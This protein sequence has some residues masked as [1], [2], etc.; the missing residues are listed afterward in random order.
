GLAGKVTTIGDEIK[1]LQY[2]TSFNIRIA[3]QM[4]GLATTVI[5]LLH[6]NNN[7]LHTLI[8]GAPQSGK[9]T[10][11]RDMARIISNGFQQIAPKKVAII[12][13]RSEIAASKNGIPQFD[14]GL[15]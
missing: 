12:D 15:R 13:E 11:L 8:V 2:I 3:Q 1:G 6:E 5:N 14:V 7:Y 10:I 9:T 4:I